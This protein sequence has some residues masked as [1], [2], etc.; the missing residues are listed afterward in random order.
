MI[1]GVGIDVVQISRMEK[2]LNRFGT[3]VCGKLLCE[4]E[5]DV[6]RNTK[7]KAKYLSSSFAVKEATVKAMGTGFRGGIFPRQIFYKK[8][9]F[10]KPLLKTLGNANL[11]LLEHKISSTH[12]S[13]SH[14]AGL[15]LANVVLE[16]I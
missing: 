3:K 10:G 13:I 12:L 2:I 6:F 5:E 16:I 4:E 7:N 8:D 15:V 14:D 9:G 11:F 1:F